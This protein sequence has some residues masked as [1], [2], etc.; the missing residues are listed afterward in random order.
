[1]ATKRALKH[2]S[3]SWPLGATKLRI[4][5]IYLR[6][7][8]QTMRRLL[9][10]LL[11]IAAL[12]GVATIVAA[13][14]DTGINIISID[15]SGFP[16]LQIFATVTGSDGRPITGLTEADFRVL[17]EGSDANLISVEEI[18][19]SD[20][21]VS[22]VLVLDSSESMFGVPLS[23][24]QNAANI[25]I[26]ALEPSDEIAVVDF[27]SVVRIAQPFTNDFNAA[28]AAI[29]GSE[30]GG[31]T[32]LYQAAWDGVETLVNSAS[33]PRR[34]LV[35]VTDGHEFGERSTRTRD[36]AIQ[37]AQ[38]SGIPVF[39]VG[40][41]SVYP[42]Y[43]SALGEGTGGR[44]YLLP[45]SAQ[46][47][48]AFNFISNFLRSQYIITIAPDL[49][50]DGTVAPISLAAADFTITQGYQKPD[51]LPVPAVI[52]VPGSPIT[53]ATD[54]QIG[55]EAPRGFGDVIVRVNGETVEVANPTFNADNTSFGGTLTIDPF[56]LAPGAYELSVEAIDAQG[57]SRTTTRPFVVA[58]LPLVL[59]LSGIELGEIIDQ[60]AP[61]TVTAGIEQ[62]QSAVSGVTFTL[63]GDEIGVDA[64]AP[65]TVDVAVQ[66]L[67]PGTYVLSAVASNTLNQTGLR[68]VTFTIPEPPTPTPT[69]TATP[70][71]PTP[72]STNTPIPPT[73]T[74]TSVPPTATP[75]PPTATATT[76]AAQTAP[77]AF[78]VSGIDLGETVDASAVAVRAAVE[79]AAASVRFVLDGE[80]I[81]VDTGA[82]Y[83]VAINTGALEP[84]AHLLDVIAESASGETLTETIP[85]TIPELVP[86]PTVTPSNVTAPVISTPAPFAISASGITLGETVS[87]PARAVR[88]TVDEGEAASIRFVL[89][90]AE[91]DLDT[92][93]P[94]I[95]TINTAALAEGAHVLEV[96]GESTTGETDTETIPFTIPAVIPTPTRVPANVTAPLITTAPEEPFS[97]SVS[98]L[99][100]SEVVTVPQVDLEAVPAE[101]S[102]V[103]S[104]TF[105]LDGELLADDAEAPYTASFETAGLEPGEHLV[106]IVA[107]SAAGETVGVDIPF[108]IPAPT[109]AATVVANATTDGTEVVATAD[110]A[111][112]T[113]DGTEVVA[114]ADA[115]AATAEVTAAATPTDTAAV[116]LAF[117]LTG[118]SPAET[119][120]DA[121]RTV[122]AEAGEGVEAASVTFSL[123]G[124][125]IGTDA[126]APYTVVVNT[127]ALA[128]GEHTL[129]AVMSS[130]TGETVEQSLTFTTAQPLNDLLLVASCLLLLGL[131]SG[132]W[133]V[134]TQRARRR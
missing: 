111:N 22:V 17:A 12:A 98:G 24:T 119:V 106:E 121:T 59:N 45:S 54:I 74:P 42:P 49:V 1:M 16:T 50:P 125:E 14:T 30:A 8:M 73:A 28:R 58:A 96:I 94:Y 62:S 115:A 71:P 134:M 105:S 91:I 84:G 99:Q 7:R 85:F 61:R 52:G 78:T 2:T 93:A 67:A 32:A 129:S 118:I 132:A 3:P 97:F 65:Y 87:D 120:R 11:L 104:I 10:L 25:L 29:A 37:L 35:L 95:T 70:L 76:V 55:A 101:G 69:A 90:G 53:E 36:E 127:G 18:V 82:P 122:T 13:Q 79:G 109:E 126:E 26:D 92:G 117:T 133:W 15:D 48:D 33:N 102:E 113:A 110:A 83:I 64:E 124:A 68:D 131:L 6:K 66:D 86:T 51:L 88:A 19:D 47:V 43:L 41:G 23:D 4:I 46:L 123:D 80:T 103:A 21:G 39:A 72:T 107:S 44:T 114:T 38:A 27:D 56:L 34:I 57:G 63:N 112:A 89:D 5:D 128:P 9:S 81:D 75:V 130:A 77:F 116:P 108:T 20:A 31:V 60:V 100:L 40:F